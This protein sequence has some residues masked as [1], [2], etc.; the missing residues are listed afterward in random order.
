M[1]IILNKLSFDY[2]HMVRP[3][4]YA[5]FFGKKQLGSFTCL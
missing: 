5:I 1:I 4:I 3:D 2:N